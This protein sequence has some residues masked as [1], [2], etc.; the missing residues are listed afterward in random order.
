MALTKPA[1]PTPKF[2]DESGDT[3]VVDR[4][5][6]PAATQAPKANVPAVAAKTAVAP[7]VK[8]VNIGDTVLNAMPPMPFNSLP[9]LKVKSGI[10]SDEAGNKLGTHIT[11][12][13]LSFNYKW[14]A[15]PGEEGAEAAK[16]LRTSYDGKTIESDG[17][18]LANYIAQ[19]KID[20]YSNAKLTKRIDVI[21]VLLSS[22]KEYE[23]KGD[24]VMVDVAPTS[25][26]RFLGQL[27]QAS[28]KVARG[29]STA[30]QARQVK[31]IAVAK[32]GGG[33]SW[34]G[35]DTVSADMLF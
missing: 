16:L 26:P 35:L 30:D 33:K 20:G 5:A 19:L 8:F 7:I 4:P 32:E 6:A 29:V 13:V 31:F 15:S 14:Q 18:D 34:S 10:I 23:R 25:V 11:V 21:G 27:G 1:A 24:L 2:E 12:E 22:D 28:M 9:T 3:A 17:S